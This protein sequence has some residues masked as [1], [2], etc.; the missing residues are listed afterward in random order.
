LRHKDRRC[1][2]L[3]LRQVIRE[4]SHH[5]L[6]LGGDAIGRGTALATLPGTSLGLATL[7]LLIL[8]AGRLVG[9][10]LQSLGLRLSGSRLVSVSSAF[11]LLLILSHTSDLDSHHKSSHSKLG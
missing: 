11:L 10:V 3:I 4:V 6:R 2:N 8:L 9:D 7:A 5:H 1:T